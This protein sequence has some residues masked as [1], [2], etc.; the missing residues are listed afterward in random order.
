VILEEHT[1][2]L[3]DGCKPV[4][5]KQRRMAPDKSTILKAELDRLLEGGFITQV[6]NTEWVSPMD[7]VPKK[8]G[9]WRICVNYKALNL[10]TKKDRQTLPFIDELLDEVAGNEFCTFCDGYS[11][12]HQ[13]KIRDEDILKTTFTTPWGTYAFWSL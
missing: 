4:R 3:K 11:G 1:I 8:G 7:I 2:D 10:V 5:E 9:K 12:Y 13:I 6:K